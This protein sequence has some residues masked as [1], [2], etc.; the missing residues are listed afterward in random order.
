MKLWTTVLMPLCALTALTAAAHA[1]TPKPAPVSDAQDEAF[2]AAI[3]GGYVF[4]VQD[5]SGNQQLISLEASVGDRVIRKL[6]FED[7][8][9]RVSEIRIYDLAMEARISLE[10]A[11]V[12][13]VEF[14][15]GRRRYARQNA[16]ANVESVAY[17]SLVYDANAPMSLALRILDT[18][19]EWDLVGDST[20]ERALRAGFGVGLNVFSTVT[21]GESELT[22]TG[23]LYPRVSAIY[24]FTP[25]L[26]AEGYLEVIPLL[27]SGQ[28]EGLD[29]A[30]Q[31]WAGLYGEA[32][33][34]LEY[35]VSRR[36]LAYLE[37]QYQMTPIT[38]AGGRPSEIKDDHYLT[39]TAGLK[40]VW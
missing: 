28:V 9:V 35:R 3:G 6:I 39:G 29:E 36:V 21:L 1:Q 11:E 40:A 23:I 14:H 7:G 4:Q 10:T 12:R 8:T 33:A 27:R 34:R 15:F 5:A 38:P 32:A 18:Q 37:A 31:L 19:F 22:G 20:Q 13:A 17:A 16:T 24:A 26:R 25:S 2:H 30:S